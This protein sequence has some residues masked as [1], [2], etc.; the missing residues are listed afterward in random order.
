MFHT[1]ALNTPKSPDLDLNCI[2]REWGR[3]TGPGGRGRR[4]SGED[5]GEK[6]GTKSG[7]TGLD[8]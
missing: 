3:K 2:E 1:S 4:K 7:I 8:R 5:G 6:K